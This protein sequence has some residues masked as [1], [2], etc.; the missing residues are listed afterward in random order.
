MSRWPC[1]KIKIKCSL[2]NTKPVLR[3]FLSE[4]TLNFAT[5]IKLCGAV[6][7]TERWDAIHRDLDRLEKLVYMKLMKF[8]KTKCIVLHVGKG[9]PQY[10]YRLE[11]YL[12][13]RSPAHKNIGI[14]LC[15]KLS[16]SGQCVVLALRLNLILGCISRQ[17]GREG[18]LHLCSGVTPPAELPPA[19]GCPVQ[20]R[21]CRSCLIGL[22]HLCY[23][24]VQKSGVVEEKR[25]LHGDLISV[26]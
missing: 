18:I 2:F 17:Q 24:D 16:V 15:V 19:L 22:E 4:G 1:R 23:E 12:I 7:M 20:E 13:E 26:F 10:Q 6:N 8:N 3:L 14:M 9:N 5:D 25:R 11:D 21:S